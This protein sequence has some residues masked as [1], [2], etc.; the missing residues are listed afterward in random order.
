MKRILLVLFFLFIV[1]V[2]FAKDIKVTW[3]KNPENNCLGGYKLYQSTVSGKYNSDKLIK[4]IPLIRK[5]NEI[6]EHPNSTVIT[7]NNTGTYYFVL[8]AYATD[9]ET[10]ESEYS[11]EVSTTIIFN[12]LLNLVSPKM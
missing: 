3:N 7:I 9:N 8:T 1:S 10:N 4:T 11:D 5:N 2:S 12:P 6:I